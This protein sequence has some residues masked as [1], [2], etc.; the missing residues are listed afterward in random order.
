MTR[1]ADGQDRATGGTA[2]GLRLDEVSPDWPKLTLA[3]LGPVLARFRAVGAAEAVVWHSG[4]P[5][6]ASAIVQG[7]GARVFVKRHDPRVRDLADLAEEHAFIAHL[8]REGAAVP[9]VLAADGNGATAVAG[10]AG[11]YEVH[12]LAEGKDSYRDAH[13]WTPLRS[14]EDAASLGYALGRLHVAAEGFAAPARTTFL[15][16]AG[17]A[18]LRA[19]DLAT[20]LAARL[21]ADDLLRDALRDRP[22]RA[23]FAEVLTPWHLALLPFLAEIE[24]LWAHG[25]LHASNLLW[26]GGRVSAV[27]DLGMCN[28]ASAP[29]DLA[30]AIER[31]AIAWLEPGVS[32]GRP[33]LARAIL[34]GYDRA[35]PRA[36]AERAALRHLLPIVHVDFALSELGYFHGVTRSA[37]NAEAAYT[38]FLLGHARWFASPEGVDFL[39]FA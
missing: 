20:G 39:R 2:H 25:D 28:R 3:E 33:A 32:K 19:P 35:R 14:G 34:R 24:P 17:D 15:V 26:Q 4:R 31:N 9:A 16:V 12:A 13:S 8:R 29:Y 6:A 10:P 1:G 22:W 11:V 23:D 36:P 38:D 27:L 7:A 30:T 5:F 37:A 21:A 18:L